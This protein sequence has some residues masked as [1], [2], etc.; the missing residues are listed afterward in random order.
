MATHLI[1]LIIRVREEVGNVL[2]VLLGFIE[3][4]DALRYVVHFLGG[5]G[6]ENGKSMTKKPKINNV[7]EQ[8]TNTLTTK[9]NKTKKPSL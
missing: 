8:H 7:G 2:S 9:Q 5:G 4:L 1:K 6:R 3:D